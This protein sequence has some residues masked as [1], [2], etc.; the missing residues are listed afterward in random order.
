MRVK[1]E[2]ERASASA[3]PLDQVKQSVHSDLQY[4]S[5]QVEGSTYGGWYR[6][7]PDGQM[8]LLALANMHC[9]RR[10]ENT[11]VEQARGMLTDFIRGVRRKAR[12]NDAAGGTLGALLY[13]D[14]SKSRVPEQEWVGLIQSVAAG[15]VAALHELYVRAHR[16]VFTLLVR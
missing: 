13:A 7:L 2:F 8:E 1:S 5:I 16:V 15:N 11:P 4:V 6:L 3:A 14:P 10:T 12:G 9:E